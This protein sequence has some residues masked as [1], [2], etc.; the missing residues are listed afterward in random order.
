MVNWLRA[1]ARKAAWA[2][3]AVF[4]AHDLGARAFGHEPV[5]DPIMHFLG[6]SAIAYFV[7]RVCRIGGLYL[8]APSRFVIDL[9]A[10]G[11]TCAV[12]LMWEFGE[13]LSRRFFGS[14]AHTSVG[15]TLRDLFLGMVGA[16]AS[17]GAVRLFTAWRNR[18]W[19]RG[20]NR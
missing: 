15:N 13:F 4:I 18:A 9:L 6:G 12:A 5:V 3:A 2:P 7:Y 1:V 19:L 16:L 10:F 20:D 14:H 11:L 8:G 17:I